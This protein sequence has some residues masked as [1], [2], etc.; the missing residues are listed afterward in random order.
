VSSPKRLFIATPTHSLAGGV[1][2]I[3]ESLA[4]HL[5]ARGFEVIFGLARGAR[6]HDPSRF[7]NAF[8][9]VR[10]VELDARSGTTFARRRA[11]RRALIE[12]DPDVVLGARLFDVYPA[13]AALKTEGHRLR[14]TTTLQAY[15][16]EYFVDLAR[17][18]ALV[19]FC[20]T[21]G[22]LI[23]E[24]VELFTSIPAERL[25]SIPGGVA[26][27]K[28]YVVHDEASP[29]RIGYVG[30]L[31]ETQKRALDL[32]QL[33]GELER[34]GIAFDC[35]VAGSGS[36]EDELRRRL[37]RVNF[38]GWLKSGALY[39]A[40]YPEIDV[41]VHFAA[42]EGI[43]IAPREAMAHGVVPVISQFVGLAAEGQFLHERNALTFPVGDVTAAADAVE[44]LDRDRRLL[45]D[46]SAEA[47]QSQSGIRS[48][49]GAADAW[50]ESFRKAL[51]LPQR[52]GAIPQP[53]SDHGR[54]S[55]MRFPDGVAEVFRALRR[56]RHESPGA[57]WPHWSGV[58]D[59]ALEHALEQFAKTGD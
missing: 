6:F 12:V 55:N 51:A 5:P 18:A 52:T 10:G 16:P 54:L 34:R 32:A 23:A 13:A 53:P 17:Y 50:A 44:R 29:I 43:T 7:L 11:L 3:L 48:E 38:Q 25:R 14:L 45:A 27:P 37:P 31:D 56:R 1:E 47:R 9:Q 21:S 30:R 8:P 15:E 28:R 4:T 59:E 20:V 46:L 24:A 22:N 41:L 2:R 39:E 57:E 40:V 36:V 19:D 42:W 26:A 58:R 49:F 35:V 33:V